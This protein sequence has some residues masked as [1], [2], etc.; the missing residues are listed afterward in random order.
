PARAPGAP[1]GGKPEDREDPLAKTL[2]EL[3]ER[4]G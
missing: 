2:R 1:A 3:E 4:R